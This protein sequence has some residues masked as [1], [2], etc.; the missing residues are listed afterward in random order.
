MSGD[1]TDVVSLHFISMLQT[2][3]DVASYHPTN[4]YRSYVCNLAILSF[5]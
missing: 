3:N 1:I 2:L 5:R 4:K